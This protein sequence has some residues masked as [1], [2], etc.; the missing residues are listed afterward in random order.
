MKLSDIRV[1]ISYLNVRFF[2]IIGHP[3]KRIT[4]NQSCLVNKTAFSLYSSTCTHGGLR[5]FPSNGKK[6]SVRTLSLKGAKELLRKFA[7]AIV[8]TWKG[9]QKIKGDEK[10]WCRNCSTLVA[11]CLHLFYYFRQKTPTTR[12]EKGT[13]QWVGGRWMVVGVSLFFSK[14]LTVKEGPSV[15]QGTN[16]RV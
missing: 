7:R 15:R 6:A 13:A 14:N 16:V 8:V 11:P 9:F 3:P 2:A 12:N 5:N 4:P 10:W 1:T